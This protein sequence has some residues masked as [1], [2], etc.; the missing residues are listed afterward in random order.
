MIKFIYYKTKQ[1]INHDFATTEN[2]YFRRKKALEK[3]GYTVER[4]EKK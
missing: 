3:K 2:K 1:G 4:L